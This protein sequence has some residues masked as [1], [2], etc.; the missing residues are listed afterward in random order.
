MDQFHGCPA[1]MDMLNFRSMSR[2][3]QNGGRNFQS[4]FQGALSAPGFFML[5]LSLVIFVPLTLPKNIKKG[6]C[7]EL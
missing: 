3:A 1:N 2:Q 4:Q 6:T 7:P 5:S